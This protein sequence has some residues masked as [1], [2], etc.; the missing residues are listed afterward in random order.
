MNRKALL[1]NITAMV[2]FGTIGLFVRAA[3]LPSGELAL[4]RTLLGS[5]FLLA[6][7]AAGRR[8]P[9]RAALRKNLPK[10]LLSGLLMGFNWVA[11]FEAY[12][13]TTV[14]VST[15]LY[16]CAPAVVLLLSPLLLHEKLQWP[17][18]A[19]VAAAMAGMVLVNGGLA[20]GADPLRGAL[21]AGAAALLYAGVILLN[22]LVHG[23]SGLET[24]LVQLLAAA[25]VLL[26]YDLAALRGQWVLPQ[27]AS[28]W[29]TLAIGLFHTGFAYLLYFSSIG[30]LGAQS[31]ALVSYA[32]P[33]VALLLSALLLGER[34]TGWQ[35]LGAA[36]ILGGALFGELYRLPTA[37]GG[38]DKKGEN[39]G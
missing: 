25:V 27:D 24:T 7:M 2:I 14:S 35:M 17:K 38:I 30:G 19:G 10:L 31:V 15:L 36:L 3:A 20:G 9:N 6:V 28:L 8:R 21:C 4:L 5:G 32:D 33:L 23:L 13:Y 12:R 11:L 29:G 22:K 26:V 39:A 16:Y 34:M 18:A 1:K 37:Q